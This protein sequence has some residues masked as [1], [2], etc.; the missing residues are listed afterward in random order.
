MIDRAVAERYE[1][2]AYQ[3]AA[4]KKAVLCQTEPAAEQAKNDPELAHAND[5]SQQSSSVL[6]PFLR[7]PN[8]L[9]SFYDKLR[10]F[11]T[12]VG[13]HHYAQAFMGRLEELA[14]PTRQAGGIMDLDDYRLPVIEG[15]PDKPDFFKEIE[16]TVRGGA[17]DIVLASIADKAPLIRYRRDLLARKMQLSPLVDKRGVVGRLPTAIDGVDLRYVYLQD[18]TAPNLSLFVRP[19]S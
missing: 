15:F 7:D 17:I 9:A 10:D 6:R 1:L 5:L 2:R 8:D 13:T 12:P 3:V 16:E 19:L 4:F 18:N 14:E 11:H